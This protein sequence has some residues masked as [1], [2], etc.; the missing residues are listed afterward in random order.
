MVRTGGSLKPAQKNQILKREV[1][2]H[3]HSLTSSTSNQFYYSINS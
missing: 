2:E 3:Q 1:G